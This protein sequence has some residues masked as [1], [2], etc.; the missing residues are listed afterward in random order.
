MGP[1][2][3][4]LALA[5]SQDPVVK[6]DRLV[7]EL[8]ARDPDINTPTGMTVD[9]KGRVW[10]IES[11]THFPPKGYKGKPTDRI[12]VFE[13][14]SGDGHARKITTFA[15]GFKHAMGIVVGKDGDVFLATRAE[16]LV[17]RDRKGGGVCDERTSIVKLDTKG[18][19][20]HNGLSGFAWDADGNL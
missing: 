17:L 19:Y 15:D 3:V 4:L 9:A 8:V 1:V 13:D 2:L 18:K 10:A 20:P 16:I 11:N 7:L 12:L 5:A 6:D 14:F